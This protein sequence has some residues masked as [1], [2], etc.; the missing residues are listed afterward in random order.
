MATQGEEKVDDVA[1][2]RAWKSGGLALPQLSGQ[3]Q[4]LRHL[5]KLQSCPLQ[6]GWRPAEP[7]SW[8]QLGVAPP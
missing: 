5:A 3:G 4:R 1:T 2:M 6:K 8:D 7:A